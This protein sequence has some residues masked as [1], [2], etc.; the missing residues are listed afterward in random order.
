MTKLPAI[1]T[2]ATMSF[3]GLAATAH[4]DDPATNSCSDGYIAVASAGGSLCV[5]ATYVDN[6][7]FVDPATCT[8]GYFQGGCVPDT[9]PAP[10][11]HPADEYAFQPAAPSAPVAR[12]RQPVCDPA[13]QLCV[14]DPALG[15]V[16]CDPALGCKRPPR[17]LSPDDLRLAFTHS[18]R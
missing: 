11:V 14:C 7:L 6:P 8:N 4:A 3:F 17:W 2:I 12:V 15:C 1:L 16:P 18:A 13:T 9:L 5:A 10:V